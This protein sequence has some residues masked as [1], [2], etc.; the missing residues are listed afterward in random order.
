MQVSKQEKISADFCHNNS[1][2]ELKRSKVVG[3]AFQVDFELW[4]EKKY[5]DTVMVGVT[6]MKYENESWEL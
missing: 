3:G 5:Y 2:G 4:V 6:P 1:Q